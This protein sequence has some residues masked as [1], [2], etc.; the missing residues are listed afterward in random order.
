M[1]FKKKQTCDIEMLM[2]DEQNLMK[3]I[4]VHFRY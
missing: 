1:Y 4:N 2:G 3:V